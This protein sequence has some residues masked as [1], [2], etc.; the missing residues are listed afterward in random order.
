VLAQHGIV[1]TMMGTPLDVS[2]LADTVMMLRFFEAQGRVRR[3]R[4]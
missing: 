4:W 1:G 2:Y 3:D